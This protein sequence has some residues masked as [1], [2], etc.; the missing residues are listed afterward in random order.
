M[1]EIFRITFDRKIIDYSLYI[2]EDLGKCFEA[3][4]DTSPFGMNH[5]V[6]ASV[7]L[8]VKRADARPSGQ[9]WGNRKSVGQG[10]GLFQPGLSGTL[11]EPDLQ[12]DRTRKAINSFMARY[13]LSNFEL[14]Q[15]VPLLHC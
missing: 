13:R 1:S 9:R 15:P 12:A 2:L 6:H 10:V 4:W 3:L 8:S 5:T 14:L 7:P 11:R